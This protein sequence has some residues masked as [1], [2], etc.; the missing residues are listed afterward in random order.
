MARPSTRQ[1]LIDYCLRALGEPVLEVNVD[2]DQ[3]EDRVDQA[4]QYFIQYH[5]SGIRRVYISRQITEEEAADEVRYLELG[6][7][8]VQVL[9]VLPMGDIS[10]TRFAMFDA[11]YQMMFDAVNRGFNLAGDLAYYEQMQQH[12]SLLDMKL[13][14]TVQIN[15]SRYNNR[16]NLFGEFGNDLKAG[17]V[18]VIEAMVEVRPGD[19]NASSTIYDDMFL[20]E[21]TTAL[22]KQQW[23]ANLIKFEGMQLPGGI[24]LNGRQIFDDATQEIKELQERLRLEFEEPVDFFVG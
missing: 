9:R 7:T 1:E 13:N 12:L 18:V 21:Y 19:A 22:I 16:L 24:T 14:G 2:P 23:G 15:F 6:D 20:K 4:I 11:S 5:S 3:L 10:N 8:V 17:D